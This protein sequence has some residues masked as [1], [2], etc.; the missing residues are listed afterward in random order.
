MNPG[1]ASS[2]GNGGGGNDSSRKVVM[3]PLP[4][5]CN[6]QTTQRVLRANQQSIFLVGM[7][8]GSREIENLQ[9][10]LILAVVPP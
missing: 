5:V 3:S 9:L 1:I 10:P 2:S 8:V 6:I 7:A 4:A